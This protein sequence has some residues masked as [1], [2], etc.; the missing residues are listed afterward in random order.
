MIPSTPPRGVYT[1]YNKDGIVIAAVVVGE[2]DGTA[3]N[4]VY[5]H[6]SDVEWESY[7]GESSTRA[8]GDGL[9]TWTRKV[10]SNGEEVTLTEVSDG[11]SELDKIQQYHWYQIKTNGD[12]EVTGVYRMPGD[13]IS[14]T[15]HDKLERGQADPGL[16]DLALDYKV[17]YVEDEKGVTQG[18][19]AYTI[20]NGANNI[21]Y[22]NKNY[23]S[24]TCTWTAVPCMLLPTTTMASL[25]T[26]M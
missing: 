13:K 5:A 20:Q 1:L 3:R 22:W 12:G 23:T 25:S 10:V 15:K 11:N 26:A 18:E 2:D 14:G 16:D 8:D 4:L 7:N 24:P 17:D 6:T 9:F 21:L 19:I